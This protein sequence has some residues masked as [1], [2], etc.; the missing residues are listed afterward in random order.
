MAL[1]ERQQLI[2]I[3]Q[4]PAQGS[5]TNSN[6]TRKKPT[7]NQPESSASRSKE[8]RYP[9]KHQQYTLKRD[10]TATVNAELQYLERWLPQQLPKHNAIDAEQ[11]PR[12]PSQLQCSDILKFEH[13]QTSRHNQE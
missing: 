11:D 9:G 3:Q 7:H 1:Q 6:G 13:G 8:H 2:G 10:E 12:Q 4:G 5:E